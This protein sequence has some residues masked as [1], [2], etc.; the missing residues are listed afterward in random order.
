MNR[1]G[2]IF[3]PLDGGGGRFLDWWG[4]AI[5]GQTNFGGGAIRR[6]TN[7]LWRVGQLGGKPILF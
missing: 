2:H 5:E 1:A 7:F 3:S 6:Q 4:G